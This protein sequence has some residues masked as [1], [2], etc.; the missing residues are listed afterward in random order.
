MAHKDSSNRDHELLT[1]LSDFSKNLTSH[2]YLENLSEF[3]LHDVC[4]TDLFAL[5]KAAYLVNNPDF[6]CLK[7]VSGYHHP[8]SFAKG[9]SWNNQ[10]AFTSHMQN[11][12][13]NKKV[14]SIQD[15]SLQLDGSGHQ[16]KIYALADQLQINDPTYH[17][18]PMKHDNSG[19]L[20]FEKPQDFGQ[21]QEHL[22]KF[23]YMFSFCPI[24]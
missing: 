24:F 3:V 19:I 11:A 14:R 15:R 5:P 18:W 8:E 12:D 7:G 17:V 23:L 6:A 9:H 13:F 1:R 16:D 10:K 2:H 20:I 4:S 21:D 22:L